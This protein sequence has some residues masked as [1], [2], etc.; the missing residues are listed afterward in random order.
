MFNNFGPTFK[1]YL[2]VVNNQMQKNKKLKKDKILL[3]AIKE[4]KTGI[5]AK[6]KAS[7]YISTKLNIK[8]QKRADKRKKEFIE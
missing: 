3:K 6:Y 5:K 1:I 2:I 4:E 7:A 8:L